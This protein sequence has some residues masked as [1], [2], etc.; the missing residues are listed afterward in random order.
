MKK[1]VTAL[2]NVKYV[3]RYKEN[4]F[5]KILLRDEWCSRDGMFSEL[6]QSMQSITQYCEA[7]LE[8]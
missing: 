1:V 5:S 7:C 4:N 3:Q 8:L 6:D 2:V